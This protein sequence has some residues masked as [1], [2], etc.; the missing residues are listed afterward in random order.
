MLKS[1]TLFC[2]KLAARSQI[3]DWALNKQPSRKLKQAQELLSALENLDLDKHSSSKTT[4]KTSGREKAAP[5]K[6]SLKKGTVEAE[7]EKVLRDQLEVIE[8]RVSV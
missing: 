8:Q 7:D 2:H 5:K 3:P 6:M 4:A 1:K